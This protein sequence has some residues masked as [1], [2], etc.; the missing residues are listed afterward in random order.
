[1]KQRL[2]LFKSNLLVIIFFEIISPTI[3]VIILNKN[4]RFPEF[5]ENLSF[6]LIRIVSE[7]DEVQNAIIR[8]LK[9]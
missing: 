9:T 5:K 2:S 3:D 8:F 1:M 7:N 6:L 4:K